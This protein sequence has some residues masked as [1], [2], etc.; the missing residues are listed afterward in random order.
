MGAAVRL[1][2]KPLMDP[3]LMRQPFTWLRFVP[4]G[5]VDE[6]NHPNGEYINQG[7]IYGHI[8]GITGVT[9]EFARSLFHLATHQIRFQAGPKV[10]LKDVLELAGRKYEVGHIR[11]VEQLG[12]QVELTVAETQV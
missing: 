3:G 11:D 5:T 1:S 4:D 7:T 9:G 10:D 6:N 12:V 2:Q 8:D